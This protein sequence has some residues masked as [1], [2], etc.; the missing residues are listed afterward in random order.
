MARNR[1]KELRT[2]Q[3]LTQ[4]ELA[5]LLEVDK[6]MVSKWE[7][8]KVAPT[9]EQYGKLMQVFKIDDVLDLKE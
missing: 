4:E 3:K 5:K 8:G 9:L 1:I 7:S 2:A 6:S